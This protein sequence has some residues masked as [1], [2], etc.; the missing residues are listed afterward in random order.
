LTR[1]LRATRSRWIAVLLLLVA[2]A[3]VG[4][5]VLLGVSGDPV[6]VGEEGGDAD[7]EAAATKAGDAPDT[8]L[9]QDAA[10]ADEPDALGPDADDAAPE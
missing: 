8:A 6:V 7:M 9:P 3:C 2:A 10:T 5:S 1:G 4:C